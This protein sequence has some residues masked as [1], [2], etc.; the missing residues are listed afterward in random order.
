MNNNI[1]VGVDADGVLTN[2]IEHNVREGKKVFK[3]EV[4]NPNEYDL[5][6]IFDL[7]DYSKLVKYAKA[8]QIYENYCKNEAPREG[9]VEVINELNNEG[10][11]FNQITAR[12]F[13]A[14]NNVLGKRYRRLLIEWN[15]K[16]NIMFDK[17][18][19]CSE[20]E[21][22]NSKLISC[23]SLNVEV[24]IEDTAKVALEL[25]E[26][27]I[28]VLLVDAPYN[29]GV[30]HENIIRIKT[31]YDIKNELKK[32]KENKKT[33]NFEDNENFNK[34]NIEEVKTLSDEEKNQYFSAYKSH[35]KSLTINEEAFKKGE[36]RF[37]MIFKSLK[38][39]V[40]KLLKVKVADQ[41]NVPYE[42]GFIVTSN[43]IDSYDQ[44]IVGLAIGNRPFT[45]LAASTIENT[46]RGRMFK[47]TNGAIFVDRKDK[48]SRKASSDELSKRIAHGKTALIFPEGTRKNK[49]EEG[50]LKFQLPFNMGAVSMAQKTGA[51]ILPTAIN[52][53]D[54][55][56]IVR[57]GK[58][59]IIKPTDD[60]VE[61]NR[62]LEEITMK[63]SWENMEYDL[64]IDKKRS[65]LNKV[66]KKE[67]N[68]R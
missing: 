10:F 61:A 7:S 35:L 38:L 32:Y 56:S 51:P 40:K 64:S 13:A 29:Q 18:K 67:N 48:E 54:N 53:F 14:E 37:K 31:W 33:N 66:Y 43:H 9:V 1:I 24:M 15:E 6:K 26:N 23:S 41:K 12:K 11:T 39:P 8:F 55:Y 45:G 34:L 27:G 3:R 21:V 17:Y 4:L 57:V 47:F 50:K 36:R 22:A 49:T 68:L 46:I 52:H 58:P 65:E 20:Y 19:F 44:F 28:K 42:D 16:H 60:L 30:E 5:E 59:I 62:R 25:A 2:L 63:L